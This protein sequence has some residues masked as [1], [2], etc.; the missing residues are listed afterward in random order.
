[1]LEPVGFHCLPGGGKAEGLKSAGLS[2]V[3]FEGCVHAALWFL[4][5][6]G[7]PRQGSRAWSSAGLTWGG[8]ALQWKQ[9]AWGNGGLRC[10]FCGEEGL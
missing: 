4:A 5:G 2:P 9:E 10:G 7:L 3:V 6:F 1:M 8:G